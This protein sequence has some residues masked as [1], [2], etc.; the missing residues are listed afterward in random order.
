MD[1]LSNEPQ[2]VYLESLGSDYEFACI[3]PDGN[4]DASIFY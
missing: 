4:H 2:V 1:E 3:D